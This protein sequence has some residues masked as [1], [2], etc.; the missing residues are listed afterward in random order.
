MLMSTM[1]KAM[2]GSKEDRTCGALQRDCAPGIRAV[3]SAEHAG[4]ERK[5][6]GAE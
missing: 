2:S 6:A 3:R 4:R 1:V 5:T